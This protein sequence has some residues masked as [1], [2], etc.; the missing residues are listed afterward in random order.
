MSKQLRHRKNSNTMNF[1]ER[2]NLQTITDVYRRLNTL[3]TI[4][5][6]SVLGNPH[7][8]SKCSTNTKLQLQL[9]ISILKY[10]L[11][12]WR[13]RPEQL[14]EMNTMSIYPRCSN[15][16]RQTPVTASIT[17]VSC[18][19]YLSSKSLFTLNGWYLPCIGNKMCFE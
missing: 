12:I 16:A 6:Y 5:I 18:I 1:E 10:Q 4:K 19:N 8:L 13:N 2:Y 14:W 17:A 3:G 11:K 7:I 15:T 9:A